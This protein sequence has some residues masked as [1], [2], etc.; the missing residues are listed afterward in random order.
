MRPVPLAEDLECC[1]LRSGT[2]RTGVRDAMRRMICGSCGC[3]P[4]KRGNVEG[5]VSG[6]GVSGRRGARSMG[7]GD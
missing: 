7:V 1:L 5:L 2:C 6:E 3:T 4:P